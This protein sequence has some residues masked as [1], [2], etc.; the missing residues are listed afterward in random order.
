M[1]LRVFLAGILLSLPLPDAG[2]KSLF[3]GRSFAGWT[4]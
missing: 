3:D 2:W 1:I 4:R